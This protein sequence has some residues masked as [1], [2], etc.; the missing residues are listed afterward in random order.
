[1]QRLLTAMTQQTSIALEAAL[2]AERAQQ[3][4]LIGEREKLQQAL[5]NSISHELRTPMVSI[6]GTLSA[7]RD[8]SVQMDEQTRQELLDGAWSEAERMNRLVQNLLEMSRLQAGTVRL[9][10]ELQDLQ[11]VIAVARSQLSE[12]IHQRD[13]HVTIPADLPLIPV[14][15]TLMA[16]VVSNLLDNALKYTEPNQRIEINACIEG[17][18]VCIQITDNGRG[19]P[20]EDL[21]HIFE[22]FYRSQRVG[23]IYGTGLG[24]SICEGIVEAHQGSIRAENRPEGGARFLIRLPIT[25]SRSQ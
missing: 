24:L 9:K 2:M 11:D 20:L 25:A 17:D 23:N 13:L 10:R 8:D 21:P 14:D 3:A 5:L 12:R 18:E 16:L 19:I 6:T 1:M 4:Q 7:L 15:V 22:R